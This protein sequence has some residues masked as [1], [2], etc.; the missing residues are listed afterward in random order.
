MQESTDNCFRIATPVAPAAAQSLDSTS[1]MPAGR[2]HFAP[3]KSADVPE[4]V[5]ALGRISAIHMVTN[6]I[7]RLLLHGS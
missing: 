4:S 6:S 2:F 3:V 1:W 5:H 7:G